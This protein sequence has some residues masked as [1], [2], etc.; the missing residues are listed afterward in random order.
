M[1]H[2]DGTYEAPQL[3][4][5][6]PA[7]A[8]QDEVLAAVRRLNENPACTAYIVQLP[9]P[10][11]PQ[12]EAARKELADMAQSDPRL[13]ALVERNGKVKSVPITNFSQ[14]KR[15]FRQQVLRQFFQKRSSL[16]IFLMGLLLGWVRCRSGSTALTWF[17]HGIANLW[18]ML[19]TV[20]KLQWLS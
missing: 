17:M 8:T 9:L 12:K 14:V 5:D 3:R 19:E 1:M 4:E 13:A 2:D 6:L 16:Q 18:S 11:G 7:T 15:T 10:K 20:A